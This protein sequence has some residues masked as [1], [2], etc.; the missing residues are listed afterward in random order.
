MGVLDKLVG[1][2]VIRKVQASVADF[3]MED[4]PKIKDKN[5]KCT[6]KWL[7]VCVRGAVTKLSVGK[8]QGFVKCGCKG[9]CATNRCSCRAAKVP[10]NSRCHGKEFLCAN[11]ENAKNAKKP[12]KNKSKPPKK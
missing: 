5:G 10:C 4:I 11:N 9:N 12:E 2:N 3:K 1:I 7:K 6:G 8:G